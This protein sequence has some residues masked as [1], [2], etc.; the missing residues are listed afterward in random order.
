[1]VKRLLVTTALEETWGHD[2][3][4]LF[5]GEWCKRYSRKDY[6]GKINSETVPYHWDSAEK[7]HKDYIYLQEVYEVLLKDLSKYL[8]LTHGVKHS[9]S[10][11]RILIGPWLVSF[12]HILFDR[13][14]MLKIAF[15]DYDIDACKVYSQNVEDFI[16]NDIGSYAAF[17][18]SDK[19]NEFIYG[20]LL[21]ECFDINIEF[22]SQE[23]ETQPLHDE[24]L[25]E[26]FKGSKSWRKSGKALLY[27][28]FLKVS[29]HF[30]K[31]DEHFFISSYLP[32]FLDLKLQY[33]LGQFPKIW[34]AILPKNN[35]VDLMHRQ[36]E[37][38]K[39]T[40]KFI[41]LAHKMALI[42]MPVVYLEGY[43]ALREET[44]SLPWPKKPKT[45]FTSISFYADDVFKAWAA[46]KCSSGSMLIIGQ[47]GGAYSSAPWSVLEDHQ[48][49]IADK[50]LSWG[51]GNNKY[52][53]VIPMFNFKTAKK[54]VRC[55]PEGD[56]LLVEL[57]NWRYCTQMLAMPI[58]SQLLSYFDDQRLFVETLPKEIQKHLQIRCHVQNSWDE[59]ERWRDDF[60]TLRVTSSDQESFIMALQK[61]RISVSTYNS[62]TFLETLTWNFPTII[63]WDQS[64]SSIGEDAERYFNLLESVG[65][66]HKSPQG[67]AQ[68]M[69][70]VWGDIPAWWNSKEVQE[71][72]RVFCAYFSQT[73][74]R[75]LERF[76]EFYNNNS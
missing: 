73:T 19:W 27:N 17:T 4:I 52:P 74:N 56:A 63:F 72:R 62:T 59:I 51:Y 13:L 68:K 29:E 1:M 26:K 48:I 60:P 36:H 23:F 3:P 69:E 55:N 71:V 64:F 2:E 10:Y 20:Q 18:S 58:S 75:P 9:L 14:A 33:K 40:D 41:N 24:T 44:Q 35:G 22:F 31:D 11:W 54:K 70:E 16:P 57:S 53:N 8:N 38:T 47:H 50:W 25:H 30:V 12:I 65:I 37:I 61:S 76:L 15:N 28:I 66:F 32:L 67:A 21:T 6:W 43:E 45:I 34:R 42:H 7:M 49:S 5:L 46:Q 39:T